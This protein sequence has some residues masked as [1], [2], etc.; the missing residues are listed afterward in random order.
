MPEEV[1]ANVGDEDPTPLKSFGECDVQYSVDDTRPNWLEVIAKNSGHR[2]NPETHAKSQ[3]RAQRRKAQTESICARYEALTSD[4]LRRNSDLY[5][6]DFAAEGGVH[7][8][9]KIEATRQLCV[10]PTVAYARSRAVQNDLRHYIDSLEAGESVHYAVFTSGNR[11]SLSEVPERNKLLSRAITRLAPQLWALYGQ[12]VI[13]KGLELTVDEENTWH[14]HANVLIRWT[15]K[16]TKPEMRKRNALIRNELG[17]AFYKDCGRL[18]KPD[19]VTKY[20]TKPDEIEGLDD[21]TFV[22]YVEQH[23]KTRVYE[24]YGTLREQRRGRKDRGEKVQGVWNSR[25]EN[26]ETT[27]VLKRQVQRQVAPMGSPD[28]ASQSLQWITAPGPFFDPEFRPQALVRVPEGVEF[29]ETALF[30]DNPILGEVVTLVSSARAR[31]QN[32]RSASG[33]EPYTLHPHDNSPEGRSSFSYSE[34]SN[35]PPEVIPI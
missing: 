16:L 29:N 18:I 11:C 15:R 31:R 28:K 34:H 21:S 26:W 19:E 17:G 1:T 33:G 35:S 2:M 13:F 14:P 6:F 5:L 25:T 9:Q 24:T 8:L 3:E 30:H 10:L 20:I 32:A 12:E 22:Q 7:K 27:V 23:F 4:T